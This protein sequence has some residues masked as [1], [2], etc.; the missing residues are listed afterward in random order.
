MSQSP[1]RP[2]SRKL[3][4]NL[5]VKDLERT[6]AF[7]TSLGFAFNKQFTDKNAACLVFS[8]DACAMLLVESFFKTFTEREL[9]DTRTHCQGAFALS[10]ESRA[11]VDALVQKAL[12]AG[13][14]LTE[15]AKDYGFMYQH[16]FDDLDHHHWEMVW[17]DPKHIQE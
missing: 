11:E 8:E 7:W 13:G 3:F 15:P 2:T 1:N 6:Q 9:C 4:L 12:A 5:P 17:M 16:G 14:T 10:C